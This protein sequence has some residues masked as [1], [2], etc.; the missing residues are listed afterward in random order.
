MAHA[1]NVRYLGS[2]K[3]SGFVYFYGPEYL[4]AK[5]EKDNLGFHAYNKK[6]DEYLSN[7]QGKEFIPLAEISEYNQVDY[8]YRYDL[9]PLLLMNNPEAEPSGYQN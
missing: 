6:I 8:E 5:Y 9:G 2:T 7:C 3:S 1:G 4:A